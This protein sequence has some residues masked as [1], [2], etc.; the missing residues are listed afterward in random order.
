MF[1][2]FSV[3]STVE[4]VPAS[5]LIVAFDVETCTAGT[6]GKKF[7]SM[8]NRPTAIATAIRMYFQR[9]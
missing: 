5:T 9:G 7:G 6:S 2:L 4:S 8:Y 1:A 3:F